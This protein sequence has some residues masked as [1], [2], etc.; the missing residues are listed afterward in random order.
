MIADVVAEFGQVFAFARMR[1]ARYAEQIHPE[2]RGPDVFMLQ[3]ISRK[4]PVAAKQLAQ[5]L[6]ID[7]GLVSRQIAKLR[8]LE[9]VEAQ[10]DETDRRSVLLTVS[11]SGR[12][13]L[14]GIHRELSAA[15]EQ[16]LADWSEHDLQTLVDLLHRFNAANQATSGAEG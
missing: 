3:I 12:E 2:L 4:G 15:Y 7:K 8:Q 6:G 10:H 13:M 16:R 1:W 5:L 11:D 9:L 14:S